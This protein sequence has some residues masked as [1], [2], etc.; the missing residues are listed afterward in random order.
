MSYLTGRFKN[1]ASRRSDEE[2]RISR[3]GKERRISPDG[4][5]TT[6]LVARLKNAVSHRAVQERRIS[7]VFFFF[8]FVV[9][10]L[11][12]CVARVFCGERRLSEYSFN[13]LGRKLLVFLVSDYI[14]GVHKVPKRLNN[15]RILKKLSAELPFFG[16]YYNFGPFKS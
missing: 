13:Y 6:Y 5:R 9:A 11:R 8:N 3:A 15:F 16:T 2:R 14:Q 7:R 10:T 4:S 1:D 12:T